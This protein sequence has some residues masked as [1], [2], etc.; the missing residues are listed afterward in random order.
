M[1]EGHIMGGNTSTASKAKYNAKAYDNI[2]VIVPKGQKAV[3]QAIA[4]RYGLSLNGYINRLIDEALSEE[5][6]DPQ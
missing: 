5:K 4:S 3:I 6:P 2:G 1:S